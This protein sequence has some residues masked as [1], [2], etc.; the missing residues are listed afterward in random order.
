VARASALVA[1]A[2]RVPRHAAWDALFVCLTLAHA[3]VLFATP[4]WFVVALALWWNA[5]TISHNFIHRPFF[6][7]AEANR[8]F[9]V[10]LSL[11]LGFPQTVWRDRHLR[12]HAGL[13][14]RFRLSRDATA[15]A[16]GVLALFVSIAAMAPRFFLT[17]YLPGW[18]AGLALCWLH[19]R[20]EHARGTTSH[21]GRIYN[22]FFFNDGY[23]IEHHT[24]PSAHWTELRHLAAPEARTSNWPAVLRW[25]DVFS[26]AGLERLV[27]KSPALQR[28]VVRRHER[29]FRKLL[30]L[31]G[32]PPISRVTIVGGGLFPRTALVIDRV[33]PGAAVTILDADADHLASARP[34]VRDTVQMR[35]ARFDE[36]SSVDSDLLV[37][38]LAYAGNRRRLYD[39]PP[40]PIVLVHDWIWSTRPRGVVVSWLLLKRLNMGTGLFSTAFNS[41][42]T[43]L[44]E[45]RAPLATTSRSGRTDE[46]QR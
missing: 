28:F 1:G 11:V 27:L 29:A 34:F 41:S 37:V 35:L 10:L 2:Q 16:I 33:L 9:A 32:V 44:P 15:E 17:A 30:S 18:G 19:G 46:I 31:P 24:R 36:N 14:E 42:G 45:S 13:D 8:A 39:A 20:Y 12:H 21:Y 6:A 22:F 25:L 23:H 38:P 7:A 4:P 5:N 26:L 43:G 40:A 3:G